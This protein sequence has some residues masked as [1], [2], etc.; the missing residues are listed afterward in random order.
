[1]RIQVLSDLHLEM[2]EPPPLPELGADV[3]VLAGDIAAGADGVTWAGSTWPDRPVIYVMGNHEYY[4][5]DAE[6]IFGAARIA[7]RGTSVHVLEREAVTLAGVRFVGTT[8]WTDFALR[9]PD[10]AAASRDAARAE[11]P[12]YQLIAHGGGALAPETSAEWHGCARTWIEH[13]LTATSEHP[14]VVV[15]HHAPHPGSNHYPDDPMAPAFV[16]DLSQLI[17]RTGPKLWVHGH[18]HASE[19]Y[20]VGPTRIVANQVGYTG[21]PT[22]WRPDRTVDV[23]A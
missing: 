21:E 23:A 4:G 20:R 10:C 19:D 17:A 22:G 9:G 13:E 11:M 8:L 1:M 3:V 16:A 15:S 18:T 2:Q 14:T 5:G 6:Q 12:D 7:A